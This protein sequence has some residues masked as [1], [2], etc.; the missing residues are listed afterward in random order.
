MTLRSSLLSSVVFNPMRAA[1]GEGDPPADPPAPDSDES[2]TPGENKDPPAGPPVAAEKDG[3]EEDAADPPEPKEAGAT[4]DWRDREIKRKH[5]QLKEKDRQAE[6]LRRENEELRGIAAAARAA[7]PK[8]GEEP[9]PAP[10]PAAKPSLDRDAVREEAARLNAQER[11]TNDCNA[12]DSAGKKAYG[13]K[14]GE[15]TERLVTLGG[16]DLDTMVY[17]LATDDPAKVMYELGSN[18]DEYHR[19]MELPFAKRNTELVKMALRGKEPPKPKKVSEAAAPV[20]PIQGRGTR[21]NDGLDDELDDTTWYA[22]REA[23]KREAF[24]KKREMGLA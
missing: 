23:Q 18:P 20:D 13:A 3:D 5:A 17:I 10:A 9:A 2:N 12:A 19:V 4:Q 24:K 1:A 21:A 22:R 16:V 15:A 11:Y 6:E 14:W 7:K 8:E